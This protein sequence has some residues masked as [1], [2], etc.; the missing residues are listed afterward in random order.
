MVAYLPGQLQI[1]GWKLSFTPEEAEGDDLF[2]LIDGGSEIY[3]EYGFKQALAAE[4]SG[5]EGRKLNI[6]I[7]RMADAASAY[8]VFSFKTGEGGEKLN[9]GDVAVIEKYYLNFYKADV[10]VSITALV[11]SSE[12][13]SD[14]IRFAE[15]ISSKIGGS[16]RSLP[17]IAALLPMEGNVFHYPKYIKGYLGLMNNYD[18]G[19]GDVFRVEEGVIGKWGGATGLVLKYRDKA[20]AEKRFTDSARAF[21]ESMEYNNFSTKEKTYSALKNKGDRI[22]VAKKGACLIIAAGKDKNEMDT[23]LGRIDEAIKKNSACD[24]DEKK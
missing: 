11:D 18:F 13:R 17:D 7:Y 10:Q 1:E 21:S 8:G 3:H 2:I 14:L 16:Q 23:I 12:T 20:E 6:E 22:V 19:M 4:Y 15:A 5:P 24:T 9:I